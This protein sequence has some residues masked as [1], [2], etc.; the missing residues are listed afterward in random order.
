MVEVYLFRPAPAGLLA[1]RCL[2][3]YLNAAESPDMAAARIGGIA[4]GPAEGPA[5]LHSTSWRHRA[6]G[7]IVL[8]YAVLPDPRP[9]LPAVPLASLG[10]ARGARPD[11][12]SPEQVNRDQVA[13]HAA[14]H[15]AMVARTDPGVRGVVTGYPAL[16][17][18]LEALPGA[19]AGQLSE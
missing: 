2:S 15:L 5:A 12:P 7:S 17:R 18:V 16:G 14:R 19:P 13:A 4:A 8:T 1:Y 6:D 9:D 11:R 3:G 10:I